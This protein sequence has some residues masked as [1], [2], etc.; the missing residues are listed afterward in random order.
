MG[1]SAAMSARLQGPAPSI[2]WLSELGLP[3]ATHRASLRRAYSSVGTGHYAG[4]LRSLP[5][6]VEA[7]SDRGGSLQ[8]NEVTLEFYDTTR[9][10]GKIFTGASAHQVIGASAVVKLAEVGV[11]GVDWSTRFTGV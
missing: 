3:G 8:A 11:A 2:W 1:L 10:L 5:G 6:I 9:E 4:L 7:V